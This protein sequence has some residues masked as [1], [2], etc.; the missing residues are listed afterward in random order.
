MKIKIILIILLSCH[1]LRIF[2]N[3][4]IKIANIMTGGIRYIFEVKG[5]ISIFAKSGPV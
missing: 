3:Q 5:W 1:L 2:L 4:E